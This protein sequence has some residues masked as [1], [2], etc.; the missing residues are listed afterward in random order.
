MIPSLK[1]RSQV[2]RSDLVWVRQLVSCGLALTHSSHWSF[3]AD[4]VIN[5]SISQETET[6]AN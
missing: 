5:L 3:Q 4:I 1:T 2:Q 6:K